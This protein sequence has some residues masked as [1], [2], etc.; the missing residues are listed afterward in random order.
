M[1]SQTI[2]HP[3]SDIVYTAILSVGRSMADFR[4]VVGDKPEYSIV[5]YQ[6]Y[7]KHHGLKLGGAVTLSTKDLI[8][9]K[10]HSDRACVIVHDRTGRDNIKFMYYNGAKVLDFTT[11]ES[12]IDLTT[13]DIKE[14]LPIISVS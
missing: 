10:V 7:L 6:A 8:R 4:T 3:D 9:G 12:E 5:E 1:E 13:L 11:T 2:E 14:V